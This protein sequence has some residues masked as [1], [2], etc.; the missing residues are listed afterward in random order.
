M[1]Q[2]A[3]GGRIGLT[4]L[5]WWYESGTQAPEDVNSQHTA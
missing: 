1:E 4:L 5:G 2:A 3:Q